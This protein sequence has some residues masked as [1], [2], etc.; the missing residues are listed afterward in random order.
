MLSLWWL[1]GP[2]E[3]ALGRARYLAL[4]L[5]SGLAGS[6]LTYLLADAEPALA[7]RLR[8]HLRPLR[9]DRRPD[10]PP[11]LRH[12][13]GHRPAGDQP[14]LHLQPGSNIAWQAHVGGLVAGVA[15]RLR[16][17]AR[18]ARAPGAGPVRRPV[19]WSWSRWSS[20]SLVRTAAAHL[21]EAV[22][23]RPRRTSASCPQR[24]AD[25]VHSC[26]GTGVPLVADLGFPRSGQGA[27]TLRG[28]PVCSH[29]GVN[30]PRVIHRSSDLFP[31]VENAVDNSGESSGRAAAGQRPLLPLGGDAESGG[32]EAEADHDVPV[33]ERV[34]RQSPSVT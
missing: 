25:L 6:A 18:A 34:D 30:A 2:L 5:L 12:A 16:H 9:R 11:Q 31:T 4:Y 7:R 13:A 15:D 33:A 26:A 24:V 19:R 23:G 27:N 22:T 20:S 32:D 1:G 14:D 21:S 28:W 8:R 10:A 29:T 3:A 17:G